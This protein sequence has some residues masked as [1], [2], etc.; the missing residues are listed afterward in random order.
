[1]KPVWR[2]VVVLA[3][4]ACAARQAQTQEMF[5]SGQNVQPVFEGWQ[6]N[7]DGT[8]SLYFGYLNRNYEEEPNVP[9]VPNNSF[10]PGLADRGQPTHFYPRRQQFV[11]SIVV[12][13]DFGKQELVWTMMHN[14][15]KSTAVGSLLPV[16]EIDEGVWR[17][18]RGLGLGWNPKD[19]PNKPPS[20]SVAAAASL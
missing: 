18:N 2:C 9:I 3:L 4:A 17:A 7:G 12:P 19:P 1:M 5:R 6:R 16:W 20:V 14:G 8:F 10:Q 13:A 11:F 15:R